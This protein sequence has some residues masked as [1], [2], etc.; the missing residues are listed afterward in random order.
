MARG[1]IVAVIPEGGMVKILLKNKQGKLTRLYGDNGT[2]IRS[3]DAAFGGV[4]GPGHTFDATAVV[5]HEIE[6]ESDGMMMT[7]F[8]PVD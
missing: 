7:S 1:E 6:Y 3:F 4:I 2:T 8:N 5:G